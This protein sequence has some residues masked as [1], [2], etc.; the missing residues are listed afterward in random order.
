MLNLILACSLYYRMRQIIP[1][2][3]ICQILPFSD[4]VVHV[5]KVIDRCV[6]SFFPFQHL[7]DF[8]FI[9]NNRLV[10]VF[11][12]L[13]HVVRNHERSDMVLLYNSLCDIHDRGGR[14][15]IERRR[16][17][18]Q[19]KKLRCDDGRHQQ[20]QSLPLSSTQQSHGCGNAILQTKSQL[21]QL[22]DK[23]LRSPFFIARLSVVRLPRL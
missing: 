3:T 8:P 2:K 20:C 15:R 4:K 19:Q 18:I 23:K 17:F 9:Q 16:M 12:C 13:L 6:L 1:R 5:E 22:F 11:Q 21:L 7:D 10:A 14:F